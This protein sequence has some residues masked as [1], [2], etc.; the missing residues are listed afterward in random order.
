M[1][2]LQSLSGL[3]ATIDCLQNQGSSLLFPQCCHLSFHYFVSSE[4]LLNSTDCPSKS[5]EVQLEDASLNMHLWRWPLNHAWTQTA[6][7]FIS[8]YWVLQRCI[9]YHVWMHK[10]A[11]FLSSN[12]FAC[13]F[14]KAAWITEA[15]W[16]FFRRLWS[17]Q[18]LYVFY[19][20]TIQF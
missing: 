16:F 9:L 20:R 4:T 6:L 11:A 5:L 13:H 3:H 12:F 17:L 14:Q 2:F 10:A 18:A 8:R 1:P 7:L 19:G 15:A